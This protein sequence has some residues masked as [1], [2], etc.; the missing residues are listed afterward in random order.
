MDEVLYREEMMW[1]QRSCITWLRE[2]DCNTKY[3]HHKVVVRAKKNKIKLLQNEN[4]QITQDRKMMERMAVSFFKDL[5]LVEPGVNTE[6][7][8]NLFQPIIYDATNSNL[9]KEFTTDEISDALFQI[10]PLKAPGP[11]GFSAQFFQRNWATLKEDVVRDV[12]VFFDSGQMPLG[13]NDTRNVLLPKKEDPN[14]LKDFRPISLCNVIYK[15]ISK[16]LVNRIRPLLHDLIAP[17][18][19]AFVSGQMIMDNVLIAFECLHALENRNNSCKKFGALKL[20]LTKAYDRVDWGFLDGVLTR[21]GFQCK[22][23]QW[24]MTCVTT[25]RYSVCFNSVSLEPFKPS[26][27]MRQGD[28]L[29]PYL[30]LFV[31][32]GLSKLIQK[33]ANDQRLKELRICRRAPGISYLLFADDMLLFFEATEEHATIMRV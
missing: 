5:Y 29:S 25:I 16:C 11:D 6:E 24:I 7:V 17:M 8:V 31:A 20:D 18:Q 9:C 15:V 27:G 1:L 21:L 22:W 23:I 4:R 2:G 26:R 3:F 14:Q 30:F 12:Q 28:L 32:D 10:G 33:E 13:V 19:S